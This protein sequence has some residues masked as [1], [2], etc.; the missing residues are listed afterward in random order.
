MTRS[1]VLTFLC[2]IFT[3]YAAW[4]YPN[5]N[6]TRSDDPCGIAGKWKNQL[7][8][9]MQIT[10]RKGNLRGK[11][12]SSV[13]EASDFYDLSGRYTMTGVNQEDCILG[14]SVAWNNDV[15]GNSNSTTS[16]T[17]LL[18]ASE[19]II[20]THWILTRYRELESMW[21]SNLVGHDDFRRI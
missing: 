4:G 6:E 20:H 8:S 7:G 14:F 5:Q 10:C 3:F 12:R 21:A 16:W 1:I 19:G 17:G 15:R 9:T 11:Y 13:G 18:Y 2:G